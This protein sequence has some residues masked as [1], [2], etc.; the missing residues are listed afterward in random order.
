MRFLSNLIKYCYPRRYRNF[1]NI[2]SDNLIEWSGRKTYLRYL[3]ELIRLGI[4]KRLNTY[5]VDRFSKSI[6]I[7]WTFR[8]PNNAILDDNRA[9]ISFEDTIKLSYKPE[10]FRELLIRAGSSR[11]V[12]IVKTSRLFKNITKE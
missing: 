10:E 9:P 12:A 5:S 8:D 3:D 6:K 2:H 4:I 1:I 7:K 11:E